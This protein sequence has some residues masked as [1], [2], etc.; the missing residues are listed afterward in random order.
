MQM[1]EF[2]KNSGKFSQ[3]NISRNI[4]LKTKREFFAAQWKNN[5][6]HW[7]AVAQQTNHHKNNLYLLPGTANC[8]EFLYHR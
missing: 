1:Y 8:E 4:K 3:K 6:W 2:I 5:L 7:A